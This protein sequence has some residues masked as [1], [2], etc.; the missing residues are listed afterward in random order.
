MPC[1]PC[2][3]FMM[4]GGTVFH[5]NE[6]K[7]SKQTFSH[8]RRTAAPPYSWRRQQ[9]TS[10][11]HFPF[12]SSPTVVMVSLTSVSP[13]LYASPNISRQTASLIDAHQT[14]WAHQRRLH[15]LMPA[16]SAG[17]SRCLWDDRDE[18]NCV[19]DAFDDPDDDLIRRACHNW[20]REE[21]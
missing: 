9:R 18:G 13:L 10:H 14:S 7:A 12:P 16:T 1:H 6:C 17:D 3:V 4:S 5:H 15:R 19:W 20:A 8:D 2:H 21:W 11:F